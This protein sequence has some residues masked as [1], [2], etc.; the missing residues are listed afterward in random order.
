MKEKIALLIE[1]RKKQGLT[2][3][4]WARISKVSASWLY[5]VEKGRVVPGYDKVL[6]L[7][8]ALGFENEW[9]K[10]TILK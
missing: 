7:G 6:K 1:E 3:Q 8:I 5:D 4:E 9:R 2:I 10:I